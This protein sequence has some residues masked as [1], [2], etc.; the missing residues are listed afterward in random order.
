M[1]GDA[2][3]VVIKKYHHRA[4]K[5]NGFFGGGR[6]ETGHQGGQIG[7]QNKN[8]DGAHQGNVTLRAVANDIIHE[9]LDA[10][11]HGIGEQ[12]FRGLLRR[13]GAIRQKTRPE[14]GKEK[15]RKEKND[16]LHGK[17]IRYRIGRIDGPDMEQS[18]QRQGR[19]GQQV[20]HQFCYRQQAFFAHG[21]PKKIP[22]NRDFAMS[23]KDKD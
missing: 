15:N 21:T 20:V 7:E 14:P 5:R 19:L 3:Q 2:D 13:A 6:G 9:I 12:E 18:E 11:T 17:S 4:T 16:Q 10:D 22:C 1:L 8:S 23:R